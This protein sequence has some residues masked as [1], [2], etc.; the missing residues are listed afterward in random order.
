M[1]FLKPH[2]KE[3]FYFAQPY[4]DITVKTN[5]KTFA[6]QLKEAKQAAKVLQDPGKSLKS[7]N[8]NDR[9]LAAIL[10]LNRYR[11]YVPGATK[12]APID[13]N[14]SQLILKALAEADWT[15]TQPYYLTPRQ[16]FYL[17]NLNAT[18]G[19]KQ[20]RNSKEFPQAAKDWLKKNQSSHVIRRRVPA[21]PKK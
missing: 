1:F 8:S 11:S 6:A 14:E 20:P 18:H 4:Y 13:K 5:D 2:P 15:Q 17:L 3:T 7:K 12:E 16:S 9:T 10:L 19:W 21:Q